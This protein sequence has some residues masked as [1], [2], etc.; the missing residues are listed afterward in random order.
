MVEDHNDTAYYL[1]QQDGGTLMD[2]SIFNMEKVRREV[3]RR[4]KECH[5]QGISYVA[6]DTEKNAII[7]YMPNGIKLTLDK[8]DLFGDVNIEKQKSPDS[9][10]SAII[11]LAGNH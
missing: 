1:K 2:T 8:F 4:Q 5:A 6:I 7:E 9:S 3:A 11:K 10:K